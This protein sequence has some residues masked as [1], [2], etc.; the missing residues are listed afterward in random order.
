[1]HAFLRMLRYSAVVL[2]FGQALLPG[3]AVKG[4]P[5]LPVVTLPLN[6][7]TA[8]LGIRAEARVLTPLSVT[9]TVYLVA[10]TAM[11]DVSV[12]IEPGSSTLTVTP[13]SCRFNILRPPS[14]GHADRPPYPAP[15]VPLCSFVIFARAGGAYPI[16]LHV[17]DFAGNDVIRPTNV[18]VLIKG[19][20]P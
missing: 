20:T 15:V 17:Q 12:S 10:K 3:C 11:S 14:V 16:T 2:L 1:M 9:V 8:T 19:E 4:S 7:R 6:M 5:P 13:K 18:T